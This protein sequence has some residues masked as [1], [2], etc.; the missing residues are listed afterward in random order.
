MYLQRAELRSL[1]WNTTGTFLIQE[2]RDFFLTFLV[3]EQWNEL[4][5]DRNSHLGE[6]LSKM[7]YVGFSSEFCNFVLKKHEQHFLSNVCYSS[8]P[9]FVFQLCANLWSSEVYCVSPKDVEKHF[10]IITQHFKS[11]LFHINNPGFSCSMRRYGNQGLCL[12]MVKIS[13]D[14]L[15]H[16]FLWPALVLNVQIQSW[17]G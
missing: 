12:Y 5:Y 2:K 6:D 1:E 8:G 14:C 10:K 9:H 15:L 17:V 7:S 11:Q 4:M 16:S 3:T 13:G